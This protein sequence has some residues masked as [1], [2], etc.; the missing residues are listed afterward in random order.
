MASSCL[1]APRGSKKKS[2]GDG[3]ERTEPPHHRLRLWVAVVSVPNQ[4]NRP[5]VTTHL[6]QTC[7][8]RQR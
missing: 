8:S 6:Q 1:S 4:S 2:T 3:A 5:M 7:Q